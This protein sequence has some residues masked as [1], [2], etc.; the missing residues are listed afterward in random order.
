M[1]VLPHVLCH[2]NTWYSSTVQKPL[3]GFSTCFIVAVRL[4][5]KSQIIIGT[6]I[7]KEY[8]KF[9]VKIVARNGMQS[10]SNSHTQNAGRKILRLQHQQKLGYSN[11]NENITRIYSFGTLTTLKGKN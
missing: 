6:L 9:A 2:V 1:L 11:Q 10:S 8:W 4:S 7:G 3:S 5:K